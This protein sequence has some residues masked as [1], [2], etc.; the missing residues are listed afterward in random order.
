LRSPG[1]QG[2]SGWVLQ[3]PGGRARG[4]PAHSVKLQRLDPVPTRLP[5]TQADHGARRARKCRQ[6]QGRRPRRGARRLWGRR[7][8]GRR[9]GGGRRGCRRVGRRRRQRRRQRVGRGAV[10]RA[11][12]R[13]PALPVTR[14]RPSSIKAPERAWAAHRQPGG[15]RGADGPRARN[16]NWPV[17][18]PTGRAAEGP[19][20]GARLR[21]CSIR[22][23]RRSSSGCLR[24][25]VPTRPTWSG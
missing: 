20:S 10:R 18:P 2:A 9:M 11:R 4:P 13:G 12:G 1:C 23:A 14:G 22:P 16:R 21:R 7:R 6:R 8:R 19:A 15:R 5:A 24:G 25:C 17:P 3:Q